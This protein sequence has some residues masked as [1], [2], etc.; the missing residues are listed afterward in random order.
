MSDKGTIK[1][2]GLG[3]IKAEG[4]TQA[5]QE[6][7]IFRKLISGEAD[8]IIQRARGKETYTVFAENVSKNSEFK[9]RLFPETKYI[10]SALIVG[11]RPFKWL[12]KQALK[13]RFLFQEKVEILYLMFCSVL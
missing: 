1:P 5:Q 7:I 9:I 4:L 13:G 6:D 10:F 11:S 12:E 2:F 8:T 3:K